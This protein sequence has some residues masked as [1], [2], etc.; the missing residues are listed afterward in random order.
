MSAADCKRFR[1]RAR[2]GKRDKRF[3]ATKT[4]AVKDTSKPAAK[5][6]K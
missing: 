3:F 4:R 6:K 2:L 5:G 1:K